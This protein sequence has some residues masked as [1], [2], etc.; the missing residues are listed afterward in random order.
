MSYVAMETKMCPVC[1]II[2]SHDSAIL[3]NKQLK[4]INPK[5]TLTGYGLCE[6]HDK[7]S[8]DGYLALIEATNSTEKENLTVEEAERTGEVAYLKREK[9]SDLFN[10][11]IDPKLSFVFIEPEVMSYLKS[12]QDN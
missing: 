11:I 4:D 9:V 10:T 8:K 7:L 6:E 1:G 5:K 12:L 3:I 2:H